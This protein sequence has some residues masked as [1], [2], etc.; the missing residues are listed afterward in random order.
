VNGSIVLFFSGYEIFIKGNWSSVDLCVVAGPLYKEGPLINCHSVLNYMAIFF[1]LAVF[2]AWKL[3][4]RTH[5]KSA[6]EIDLYEG[7]KEIVKHEE[8]FECYEERMRQ[9]AVDE[10]TTSDPR[11]R[12][13][14]RALVKPFY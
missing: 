5:F 9:Q 4:R 1:F 7:Q 12:Q 8:E 13:I 3:F 6:I 10:G 11:W 2:L 14:L